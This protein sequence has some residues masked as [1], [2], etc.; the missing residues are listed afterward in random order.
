MPKKH[1]NVEF[2][3]VAT[4]VSNLEYILLKNFQPISKSVV[5]MRKPC[6]L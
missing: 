4:E 1:K 3:N 2:K 5:E 6:F